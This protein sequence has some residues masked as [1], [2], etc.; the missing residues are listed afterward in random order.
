MS[1]NNSLNEAAVIRPR[2]KFSLLD[3][4]CQSLNLFHSLVAHY[5]PVPTATLT[6]VKHLIRSRD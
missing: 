3:N 1:S 6:I 5:H 2:A 4:Y